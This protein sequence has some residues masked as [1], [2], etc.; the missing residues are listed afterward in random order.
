MAAESLPDRFTV[1]ITAEDIALGERA[2]C[3][4]CPVSLALNRAY[5]F[6]WFVFP[7]SAYPSRGRWFGEQYVHDAPDFIE[8]FDT[9]ARVEPRTVTLV[10]HHA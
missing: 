3:E 8:R 4:V 1:E 7:L 10:R 9:G 2:R 5:P 6:G